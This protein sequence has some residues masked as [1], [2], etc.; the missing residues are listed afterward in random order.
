MKCQ[1]QHFTVL[2]FMIAACLSVKLPVNW[3]LK[4]NFWCFAVFQMYVL[5]FVSSL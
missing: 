1:Q 3:F 2:V 4:A 5:L